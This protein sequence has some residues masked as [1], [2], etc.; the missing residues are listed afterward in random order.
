LIQ[1]RIQKR[2]LENAKKFV[3]RK[4]LKGQ[5]IIPDGIGGQNLKEVPNRFR[6]SSHVKSPNPN[7][8]SALIKESTNSSNKKPKEA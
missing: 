3:V 5:P 8:I 2:A 4:T 7:Y 1:Q 6:R